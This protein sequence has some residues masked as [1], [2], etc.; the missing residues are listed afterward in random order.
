MPSQSLYRK[1]RAR[2]FAE[3]I[4][5]EHITETLTNALRAGRISHAYLFCGPRGTGKTSTARL[6]AKA[7][8]CP[9]R[10]GAEPCDRCE[11]CLAI[12][13]GRAIDL[14][15]ID[16]ASN[17]GID[18]IR[19]LRDKVNF[20]PVQARY[21]FYILDEA[22]MLT[23]EAFNALLKTLEE[24]PAHA[25]FV[26][27]TTEPHKIPATI[28]SRCQRFDFRR[29]ALKDLLAKL[30]RICQA[31]GLSVEPAA[32]DLIARSATGS[33]RDAESL[34]D[35][36]AAYGSEHITV[37]YVQR[38]LGI[39]PLQT[40]SALVER[41]LQKDAAGGL[42]LINEV[43]DAGA[44]LRQYNRQIVSYLRD[45]LLIKTGNASLVDATAEVIESMT[46]QAKAF[47]ISDLL[48]A[49]K[50]FS[51]ADQAIRIS[52]L[53]QLPLE[54]A[55]LNL[56]TGEAAPGAGPAR[57][58]SAAAAN[59]GQGSSADIR[60]A[61]AT[62]AG[63]QSGGTGPLSFT[64]A[65][66]MPVLHE[67]AVPLETTAV[68]PA[69]QEEEL[70]LERVKEGWAQVLEAVRPQSRSVEGLLRGCE[71]VAMEDGVVVLGFY[72]QFHKE[73]IEEP[74]NKAIVE[75][76]LSKALGRAYR[77]RCILTPRD[78]ATPGSTGA[79]N[80]T[81]PKADG[82]EPGSQERLQAIAQDPQVKAVLEVFPD[83]E[84]TEVT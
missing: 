42:R 24:P 38:L 74:K 4:G 48:Q 70:A 11:M 65:R 43:A 19:D 20:S 25:I 54:L 53:P 69:T 80:R 32:L 17:R 35:Q 26:L 41:L 46:A 21:R 63:L 39:I 67:T 7:V 61:Q 78:K 52:P 56:V 22:H 75:K 14:I 55:F 5:Q 79:I 10:N 13:E 58:S 50:L 23:P 47:P 66:P 40:I 12:Q 62:A 77:I 29:I 27:V 45:L 82:R 9:Q 1:W 15:E 76:A 57:A 49:L 18:E 60:L 8:N 73:R 6:L 33:L 59:M 83:A 31:E 28:V 68:A 2:T 64:P 3:L 37:A 44:D 16:A 36:L 30:Q 71:P 84:I 72:Y 81:T 51:Q 34:L